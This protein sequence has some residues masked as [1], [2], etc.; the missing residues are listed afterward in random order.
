M[1]ISHSVIKLSTGFFL[2]GS[3]IGSCIR[4][5]GFIFSTFIF[6][7]QNGPGISSAAACHS[8]ITGYLLLFGQVIRPDTI[9]LEQMRFQSTDTGKGPAGAAV[10]ARSRC[11][12]AVAARNI[13]GCA[14]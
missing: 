6:P 2:T 9:S 4:E 1:P 13:W 3:C 7:I 10:D 11:V 12:N 14:W 8:I 5:E